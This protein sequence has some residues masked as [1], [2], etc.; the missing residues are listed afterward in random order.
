MK[1]IYKIFMFPIF[2]G[3]FLGLTGCEDVLDTEVPSD[4]VFGDFPANGQEAQALLLGIYRDLKDDYNSTLYHEDR[5]DGFDVGIIGT[6]SD[7]WS[8]NIN[9][10]NGTS[11]TDFYGALNNINFLLSVADDLSFSNEQARNQ[12]KAEALFLRATYYFYITRIW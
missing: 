6:V 5:G 4:I 9:T 10:T 12:M 7:A 11:W 8:H 1:R 2:L 3:F